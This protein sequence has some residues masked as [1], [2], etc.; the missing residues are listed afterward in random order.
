MMPEKEKTRWDDLYEQPA[1]GMDDEGNLNIIG[2]D[3]KV[4]DEREAKQKLLQDKAG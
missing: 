1:P 3:Q 4:A 2:F